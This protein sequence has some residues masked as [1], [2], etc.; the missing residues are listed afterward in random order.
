MSDF[1]IIRSSTI[2]TLTREDEFV[3]AVAF[4]SKDTDYWSISD[5]ED[6][7]S[8]KIGRWIAQA[9]IEEEVKAST[10]DQEILQSQTETLAKACQA[11]TSR[12]KEKFTNSFLQMLHGV[13]FEF[14]YKTPVDDYIKDALRRYE[15]FAREWLNEIFLQNFERPQIL[16]AILRVISH[17]DYSLMY[18]QG[19]TIAI[20]ATRHA[21][22]EVQECG[23]RCFENWESPESLPI[24]RSLT[25]PEHWLNSYLLDVIT[26]LEELDAECLS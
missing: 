3:S 2:E 12:A 10:V 1:R 16:S 17:I 25:F 21:D 20:A 11:D 19:V 7:F 26:D 9:C 23:V 18:P 5:S 8:D 13:E 4:S 22:I 24:L 6:S 15:T 14:G